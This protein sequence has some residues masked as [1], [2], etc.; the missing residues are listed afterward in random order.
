MVYN[1]ILKEDVKVVLCHQARSV[2]IESASQVFLKPVQNYR[3]RKL[4]SS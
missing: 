1:Y 3:G 2:V 4:L